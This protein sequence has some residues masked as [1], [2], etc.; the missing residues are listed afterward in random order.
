MRPA[1]HPENEG[2]PGLG[3]AVRYR[4]YC[5][6]LARW[7][8]WQ[9]LG[10]VCPDNSVLLIFFLSFFLL[11]PALWQRTELAG[12]LAKQ[13]E[14]ARPV[15]RAPPSLTPLAEVSRHFPTA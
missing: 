7:S 14:R 11:F 5:S 6:E 15:T 4:L 12:G 2:R 9:W 10:L 8:W 1:V 3:A 13:L